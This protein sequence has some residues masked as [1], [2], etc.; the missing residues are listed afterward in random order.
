MTK[1]TFPDRIRLSLQKAD[2]SFV[3]QSGTHDSS[4]PPVYVLSSGGQ[5]ARPSGR[6]LVRF[7]DPAALARHRQDI[8]AAGYVIEEVLSYAPQAAWVRAASGN[9][10]EALAAI[11]A[12]ERMSEVEEVEPQML[13]ARALKEDQSSR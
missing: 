6:V 8:E 11:S 9:P 4:E 3:K 1:P 2:Q 5:P 10:A 12:L 13:R 7:A